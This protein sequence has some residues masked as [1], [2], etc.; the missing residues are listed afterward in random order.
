MFQEISERRFQRLWTDFLIHGTILELHRGEDFYLLAANSGLK[1]T[2]AKHKR[3]WHCSCGVWKTQ[4]CNSSQNSN[5][6]HSDFRQNT[7]RFASC[8]GALACSEYLLSKTT[9]RHMPFRHVDEQHENIYVFFLVILYICAHGCHELS[10]YRHTW[11]D[12]F[13]SE[14]LWRIM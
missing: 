1:T 4:L 6:Q 3:T 10:L 13:S 9:R 8:P 11:M 2:K 5:H 12:L 14:N 7:H